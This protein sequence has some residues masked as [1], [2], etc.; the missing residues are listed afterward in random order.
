MKSKDRR[1][2]EALADTADRN[3]LAEISGFEKREIDNFF[4]RVADRLWRE[5]VAGNNP[6]E[7]LQINVD[8]ASRGNP[9]P[10]AA[11]VALRDEEGTII[12]AFGRPLGECT[13]NVAEYRALVI[14]LER[15]AEFGAKRVEVFTDS[16]LMEKQMKGEYRVKNSGIIPLYEKARSLSGKFED[17]RITH[18]KRAEN[19]YA[20]SL[21]NEALDRLKKKSKKKER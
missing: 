18:V 9:G 10:S 12:D 8:G 15:A 20:D 11:G 16:Q 19:A 6:I 17:F 2:F 1:I 3:R 7:T 21:A 14:A 13:N 4:I 5:D